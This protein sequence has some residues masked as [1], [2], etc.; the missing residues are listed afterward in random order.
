ME[1]NSGLD[2]FRKYQLNE[3][4]LKDL[5]SGEDAPAKI[6]AYFKS[7]SDDILAQFQHDFRAMKK[8]IHRT[9]QQQQS[10]ADLKQA[11][12]QKRQEEHNQ[13]KDNDTKSDIDDTVTDNS[14]DVVTTSPLQETTP[15][16]PAY[17]IKETE[18]RRVKKVSTTVEKKLKSQKKP[19]RPQ[20]K[21][22]QRKKSIFAASLLAF[23]HWMQRFNKSDVDK[24]AMKQGHDDDLKKRESAIFDVH[25]SDNT[26]TMY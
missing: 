23:K 3:Q 15:E 4:Q 18:I 26:G 17:D 25:D 22:K 10:I 11:Y 6:E 13:K 21:K 8:S 5:T 16:K 7:F 20:I 12:I 19:L 1:K 14:V 9:P 24:V 2:F